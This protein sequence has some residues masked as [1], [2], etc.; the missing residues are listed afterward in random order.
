MVEVDELV[1]VVAFILTVCFH[2]WCD[3]WSITTGV[4]VSDFE[5]SD[6]AIV[7]DFDSPQSIF[8]VPPPM[9]DYLPIEID[10]TACAMEANFAAYTAYDC[11]REEVVDKS[12]KT[13]SHAC[14]EW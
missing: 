13:V 12:M 4:I 11:N 10:L 3:S 1:C 5:V 2:C 9:E 6:P 8:G 14:V 7:N